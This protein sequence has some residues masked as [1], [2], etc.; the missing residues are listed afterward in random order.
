[1]MITNVDTLECILHHSDV[2]A[3][4]QVCREWR[5][6]VDAALL[7][8]WSGELSAYFDAMRIQFVRK[9]IP[10]R[11]FLERATCAQ[12][13]APPPRYK[14]GRCEHEV[15]AIGMCK[16]CADHMTVTTGMKKAFTGPALVVLTLCIVWYASRVGMLRKR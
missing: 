7:N 16:R 8:R 2:L 10:M 9:K 13:V 6:I 14:C 11:Y 3:S 1:M 15:E 12:R 4:R 5:E